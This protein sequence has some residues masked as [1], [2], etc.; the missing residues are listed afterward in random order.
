MLA[1]NFDPLQKSF[2]RTDNCH[3][4]WRL[5]V[6]ARNAWICCKV[7]I[8]GGSWGQECCVILLDTR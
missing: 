6:D 4:D 2:G 1:L 7:V 8:Q 5:G 3:H